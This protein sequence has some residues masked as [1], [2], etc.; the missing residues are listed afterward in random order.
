MKLI[1]LFSLTQVPPPHS[2]YLAHIN[3]Y[4]YYDMKDIP[5]KEGDIVEFNPA[6]NLNGGT[7]VK[8]KKFKIIKFGTTPIG[9]DNEGGN[10]TAELEGLVPYSNTFCLAWL[11]QPIKL[12]VKKL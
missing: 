9:T 11:K 1:F 7:W 6:Y 12:K 4:Q 10:I 2:V 8:N 5:F 3:G